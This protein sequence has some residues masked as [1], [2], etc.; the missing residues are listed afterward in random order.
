MRPNSARH[1]G[2]HKWQLQNGQRAFQVLNLSSVA[3]LHKLPQVQWWTGYHHSF[4]IG[5]IA[6]NESP[7]FSVHY[8]NSKKHHLKQTVI[9][10]Q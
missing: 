3:R 7:K 1:I 5:P 8:C 10:I 2:N 6:S 9:M 4:P